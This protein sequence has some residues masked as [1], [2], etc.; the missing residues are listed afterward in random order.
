MSMAAM[1]T[2]HEV[3][4]KQAFG[5]FVQEVILEPNKQYTDL[6]LYLDDLMEYLF[7]QMD[8]MLRAKGRGLIF[9]WC[10]SKVQPAIDERRRL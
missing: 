2:F 3:D 9:W 6:E 7:P 1:T 10:A 4:R 5:G 8:G